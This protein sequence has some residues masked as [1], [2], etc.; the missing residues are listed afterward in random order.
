M[1]VLNRNGMEI[2][3][4]DHGSGV[5]ILL[6]MGHRYSARMWYPVFEALGDRY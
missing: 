5:P 4:S 3:W 6:I 1:P 2:A